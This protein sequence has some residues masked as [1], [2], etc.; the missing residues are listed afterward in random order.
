VNKIQSYGSTRWTD[1]DVVRL[2]LRSFTVIDPHLVNL[3]C[4]LMS[5]MLLIILIMILAMIV[6][7]LAL[8]LLHLVIQIGVELGAMILMLFLMCLRI[9]MHLMDLHSISHFFCIIC[10]SL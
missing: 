1:H 2:M 5:R 9:G 8:C 10:N 7:L 4:I 6:L 3:I